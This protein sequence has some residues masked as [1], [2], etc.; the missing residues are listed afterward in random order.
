[1]TL[2]GTLSGS[3]LTARLK[4]LRRFSPETFL[5]Q[6]SSVPMV[7]ARPLQRLTGRA[8]HR[9]SRVDRSRDPPAVELLAVR[10]FQPAPAGAREQGAG[11]FVENNNLVAAAEG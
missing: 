4:S 10:C 5:N 8:D 1:M 3:S 9:D 11:G 7:V 6:G 2:T